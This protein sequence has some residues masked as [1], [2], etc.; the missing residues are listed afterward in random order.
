MSDESW[1][2]SGVVSYGYGC[3]EKGVP[4]LYT[5]VA[6]YGHWIEEYITDIGD[7]ICGIPKSEPQWKASN[8]GIRYI[9]V[10]DISL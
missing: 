8:L 9:Y 5:N 1:Y 3:A 10:A 7:F 6:S 4:A 2:L